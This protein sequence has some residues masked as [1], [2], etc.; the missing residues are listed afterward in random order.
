MKKV[1]DTQILDKYRLIDLFKEQIGR[2]TC[3]KIRCQ[4][5]ALIE[6]EKIKVNIIFGGEHDKNI[7]N[8]SRI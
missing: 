2:K 6:T 7:S 4:S 3:L 1:V 8:Y 5:F